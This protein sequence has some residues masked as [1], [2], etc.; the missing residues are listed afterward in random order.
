M[1]SGIVSNEDDNPTKSDKLVMTLPT[2]IEYYMPHTSKQG[3][4]MSFKVTL[5][6]CLA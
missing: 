4:P 1:L 5:T 2:V 6:Y 3:H